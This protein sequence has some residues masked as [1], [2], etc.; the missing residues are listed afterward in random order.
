VTEKDDTTA[1]KERLIDR[2]SVLT[3]T[4]SAAAATLLGV[5][6]ASAQ[7]TPSKYM[8]LDTT[9]TEEVCHYVV[10]ASEAI[11]VVP[12]DGNDVATATDTRVEGAV[13][14]GYVAIRYAG[15][16]STI[17]IDG[18][19]YVRFGDSAEELFPDTGR[20]VVVTSP[21]EVDYRFTATEDVER[22]EDGSRNAAETRNDSITEND[23]GTVTA[24]GFTGNG[25]GDSF[26]VY[27][28]VTEFT[29]LEGDYTITVDG[30]E[31]SA[32]ELTGQEP[33]QAK[34]LRIVSPSE[35]DYTFTVTDGAERVEDGSKFAA[36]TNND[37]I[38]QNADGTYQVSGL[39]GNGY[40]DTF[41][42][43]GDVTAFS[44][45][46][47][48]FTLTLDGEEVSAY[49]LTGEEPPDN[50]GPVIGGGEGYANTVSESAADVVVS[51]KAQLNDALQ[52]ASAGDVVYV[53]GDAD[54]YMG[55]SEFSIP[56]GV[57]LASDRGI[58]GA[59]GGRLYTDR[60]PWPMLEAAD[61]VRVTG[62]RIEGPRSDWYDRGV[63]EQGLT[64]AGSGCE[65]DN[66]EASGWG[67]AAVR[68]QQ[69]AHVHHSE[70]HTNT[71]GGSGYGVATTS[72]NDV[73]VEYNHFYDNRHSVE[74]TGG[75]YTARYNHVTGTAISHVF[76]QHKP[77][78]DRIEINNNTVEVVDHDQ[79]EK[80]APA[81]AIRGVP[82]DGA[83]V[84]DNWFY[85][86][87]EPRS[88]PDGWTDEAI[89][90]VH[91][92]SWQNVEFENN[93]YGSS[94]PSSS[95]IGCP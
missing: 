31:M 38:E 51:T 81:V 80:N 8:L 52:S 82:S 47:G 13:D 2:R 88:T 58:D 37:T 18:R 92:T 66:V 36:E 95:D 61:D 12:T 46:D 77:G 64:L 65:V 54:I 5:G 40:G 42:L 32:Y 17:E 74:S 9:S 68:C 22:I 84:Y 86:P 6:G 19:A 15:W 72:A 90:Q 34:R 94:E 91:T 83:Y 3:L 21:T 29:P 45:M 93:H 26:T 14:Q 67:W 69:S 10:E 11:E 63:L 60:H 1:G 59:A 57:T 62:L 43:T 78:G 55:E 4:G 75:D 20:K 56:S 73:I 16:V 33:E 70:L 76:D 71:E 79:K 35:I 48:D 7:T 85:N 30:Q 89:I 25:Y 24:D 39:T 49:E 53:S 23:D 28:D 27:G 44:P 50:D 41:D 87:K